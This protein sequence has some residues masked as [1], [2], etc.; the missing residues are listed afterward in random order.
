MIPSADPVT[1][2]R[3]GI[4]L[5]EGRSHIQTYLR[6]QIPNLSAE[7]KVANVEPI[8]FSFLNWETVIIGPKLLKGN[9]K[10]DYING[11]QFNSEHLNGRLCLFKAM[12]IIF[13]KGSH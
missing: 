9:L 2:S 12:R 4:T 5:K 10:T 3:E 8:K 13:A 11:V 1:G 6:K 7:R